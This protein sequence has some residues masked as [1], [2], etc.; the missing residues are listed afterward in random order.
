MAAKIKDLSAYVE[1]RIIRIP[2][3]GCWLWVGATNSSGYG[4]TTISYVYRTA[5][6][7]SWEVHRGPIPKNMLVLHKCDVPSCVNPDHLF[8]GTNFDNMQDKVKKGR[9]NFPKGEDA[10]RAKLSTEEV[11]A[12]RNSAKSQRQLAKEYSIARSQVFR[13][14]H[15]Q[16]WTWLE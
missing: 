16:T 2:I 4:H 14:K 1:E 12:I 7:I 9:A 13:I 5:H 6:R 8:L 11:L 3:A 15:R 10:G